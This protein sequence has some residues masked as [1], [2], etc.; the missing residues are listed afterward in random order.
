MLGAEEAGFPT[1]YP[2]YGSQLVRRQPQNCKR[3]RARTVFTSSQLGC[4]ESHF[5]KH[6]YLTAADRAELA[7]TL[8]LTEA[9]IKTWFQVSAHTNSLSGLLAHVFLSFTF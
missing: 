2:P 9:Q 3:R 6:K 5:E 7:A 4:L 1:Y 8:D